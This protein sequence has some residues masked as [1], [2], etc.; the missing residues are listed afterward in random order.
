MP[1]QIDAAGFTLELN[2]VL[3]THRLRGEEL[4]QSSDKLAGGLFRE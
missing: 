4:E 3:G 2:R 1:N